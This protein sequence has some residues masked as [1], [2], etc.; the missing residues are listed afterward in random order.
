MC[1]GLTQSTKEDV[2]LLLIFVAESSLAAF[3]LLALALKLFPA[4][5]DS[6]LAPTAKTGLLCRVL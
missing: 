3:L 1:A 2:K 6:L 4:G 5:L